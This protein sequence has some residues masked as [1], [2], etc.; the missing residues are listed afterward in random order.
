VDL[1][2]SY[3][4]VFVSPVPSSAAAMARW[5]SSMNL[6]GSQGW[7]AFAVMEKPNGWWVL[8]RTPQPL[9]E[10]PAGVQSEM[11]GAAT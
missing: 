2:W 1:K 8:F 7:E 4:A 10:Q 9:T 3:K 6:H 5:Q 11:D